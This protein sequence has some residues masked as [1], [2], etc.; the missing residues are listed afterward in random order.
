MEKSLTTLPIRYCKYRFCKGPQKIPPTRRSDAIYC[1]DEHGIMERNARKKDNEIRVADL[2]NLNTNYRILMDLYSRNIRVVTKSIL[3]AF[4]FN[5]SNI[6][7]SENF[8]K[9]MNT[10]A[11]RIFDFVLSVNTLNDKYTIKK[12]INGHYRN[13]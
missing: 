6:V 7:E 2:N 11:F 13:S 4:G 8:D 5:F 12:L 9:N 1:C 3:D 10:Q